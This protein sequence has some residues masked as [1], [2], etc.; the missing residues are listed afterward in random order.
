[1]ILY[2]YIIAIKKSFATLVGSRNP[3]NWSVN[4]PFKKYEH[5]NQE[6]II[7]QRNVKGMTVV[8]QKDYEALY[9][10]VLHSIHIMNSSFS[11]DRDTKIAVSPSPISNVLNSSATCILPF[12]ESHHILS[13]A[14]S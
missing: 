14:T 12:S 13:L 9:L 1:M 10:I 3:Y 6:F 7:E 4:Y 8:S 11:I 5:H 2:L